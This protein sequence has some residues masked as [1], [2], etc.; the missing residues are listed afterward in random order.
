[1]EGMSIPLMA[2]VSA[3]RFP[4]QTRLHEADPLL[5]WWTH[6]QNSPL[7]SRLSL[8]TFTDDRRDYPFDSLFGAA[9]QSNYYAIDSNTGISLLSFLFAQTICEVNPGFD[10]FPP[11]NSPNS[12]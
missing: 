6:Q 9:D 11:V 8:R 12:I 4:L 10:I 1:M 7:L 5:Q 2:A 3:Y